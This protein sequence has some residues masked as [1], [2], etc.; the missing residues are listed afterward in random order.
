M[1]NRDPLRQALS[2]RYALERELGRGGMATVYLAQDLKHERQVA[3]KVLRPD[4]SALIGA[5]RFVREIAIVAKLAHP[6]VLPLH[7]SGVADGHLYYVMPFVEGESL[8]ARL[9][10]DRQL[11]VGEAVRIGEEVADALAYAH[12]RGVVHR[13]IKPENILLESGHA[14]VAD[15]GIARV[16]SETGGARLTDAGLAIGTAG[17]M[18]PEQA[19]GEPSLD[20]RA[21]V[22]SAGCVV[23]E[24][25][26]GE[27]P[28][29]GPTPQVVLARALTESVRP[30]TA[31]REAVSH[32]LD[33]A[34]RKALAKSPADRYASAAEF[35]AALRAAMTASVAGEAKPAGSRRPGRKQGL[36]LLAAVVAIVGLG[37]VR[38]FLR[39]GT[40]DPGLRLA[41]FPFLATAIPA[42]EYTERLPALLATVLDGTPGF[43]VAD[44]WSL[45]GGL[46]PERGARA[47]SPAGVEDASRR[48]RRA[49]A[50]MFLLGSIE[51][52]SAATLAVT[53]RVYQ[54]GRPDAVHTL[55]ETAPED[56]LGPLAHRLA[57][58]L[59]TRMRPS[60]T[61]LVPELEGFT[62]R[63]PEAI[64]AYLRAKEAMRRGHVDSADAEIDA[65]IR[66]DTTFAVALVEAVRI[67][68]YTQFMR[69][70]F[71]TG[72]V[73]LLD[74]A[75]RYTDSLSP[76]NRL[77]LQAS[78]ASVRT[79]GAKAAA[80]AREI[81]AIDSTDLDAW[82]GLAY[83]H[84]V[85]GWQYGAG[86]SEATEALEKVIALDSSHV[87]AL[88]SLIHG[89]QMVDD[90]LAARYG[91]LLRR[92]DTT[93]ALA[94]GALL[95]NRVLMM[96]DS[97]F[98]PFVDTLARFDPRLITPALRALRVHR[99]DRAVELL[100]R[101]RTRQ[102][103]GIPD[104]RSEWGRM[105]AAQGRFRELDSAIR[106]GAFPTQT[107]PRWFLVASQ[108]ASSGDSLLAS[109]SAA[110][111]HQFIPP[112]SALVMFQRMP[113]WVN[114]W[115]VGA[116]HAAYA[117]TTVA[118]QWQTV[119][120]T[121]PGGGTSTDYRGSMQADIES[122]LLERRGNLEGAL[123]AATRAYDLW[124][125]HTENVPEFHPEPGLRFHLAML[126]LANRNVDGARELF[127]SLVPPT[128]WMGFL[129]ARASLELGR[130]TEERGDRA[131][132][133]RHYSAAYRFYRTADPA[134]AGLRD[135]A[136]EGLAR[137]T[138][139]PASGR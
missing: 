70:Q 20:Q 68:S 111:L 116:Y 24:M 11:P 21:D 33:L 88:T 85:Y 97:V 5:E 10:R 49:H 137:L 75:E 47:Q 101:L 134:L 106:T 77:R 2:E 121:L 114:G 57:V 78:R 125:I 81:L 74:R 50:G 25:L 102:G 60:Q 127:R 45:W 62:T 46:R 15:F 93:N 129:T 104:Y 66:A 113:V 73:D 90:T 86:E 31:V 115:N 56:S 71:F 23:Y 87:P 103:P 52:G 117:D 61:V 92:A 99:P 22:Y 35:G 7:D 84:R 63:S 12:S 112:D 59:I 36:L 108:S 120:G 131:V 69:G 107:L 91:D 26:S 98:M 19:S 58:N 48:A 76:R 94:R 18:S 72:L 43:R 132:A 100:S 3:L 138:G 28:H 110:F 65:A 83:Y 27:P 54:V 95:G 123:A 126:H 6:H 38:P 8:R 14:V 13:D 80:A 32:Q 4:I 37:L 122:R 109:Q 79:E 51:M 30:L 128:T 39:V 64:K 119:L 9:E 44:P 124:G 29:T 130:L 105:L 67:K 16:L 139:E 40:G 96:P 135:A 118:R 55:S 1:I 17:Y 53:A 82:I 136:R 89:L 34:V 41:V 42:R 133:I